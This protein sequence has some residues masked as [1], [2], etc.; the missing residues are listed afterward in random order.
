M[1]LL[2]ERGGEEVNSI[3]HTKKRGR[4][5]GTQGGRHGHHMAATTTES[6]PEGRL[7]LDEQL[8]VL[9][10]LDE[11]CRMAIKPGR[12]AVE[13]HCRKQHK[14]AGPRLKGVLDG[15][16]SLPS[17]IHDPT[18][19]GLPDDGS[20]PVEGIQV[21]AGYR[22]R[23]CRFLTRDRTNMAKHQTRARHAA[24][25]AETPPRLWEPV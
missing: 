7:R 23:Y 15:V 17:P 16:A 22:C 19:V 11:G 5:E 13:S 14:M 12:R 18:T 21:Y 3:L 1:I 25:L 20:V 6:G 8:R 10:C 9:I 24:I 2:T 4:E